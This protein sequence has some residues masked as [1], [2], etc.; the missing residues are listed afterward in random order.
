MLNNMRILVV[1]D[2]RGI[3]E[4]ASISLEVLGFESVATAR[5]GQDALDQVQ[6][7]STPF[8]CFLVDIQMPYVD[9]FELCA[10]IRSMPEYR[11][12]PI[13]MLTAMS[14]RKYIDRALAAGATD[15]VTKPFDIMDL[16]ARL[17]AAAL[18]CEKAR[19]GTAL[20]ERVHALADDLMHTTM[21]DIGDTFDIDDVPGYLNYDTF[22]DL[23]KSFGESGAQ[24]A[25]FTAFQIADIHSIYCRCGSTAYFNFICDVSDAVSDVVAT[26][27]YIFSYL[28]NGVFLVFDPRSGGA[29][30]KAGLGEEIERQIWQL[31]L[32]FSD[33][34]RIPVKLEQ[35]NA[36]G[37]RE[38]PRGIQ[39]GLSSDN[40]QPLY[41]TG[42]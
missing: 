12:A 5:D 25:E 42:T 24:G 29:Q 38:M 19:E 13:I 15:Y 2:D 31:D 6:S 27:G 36:F 17:N 22:K 23:V 32:R 28:G 35:S 37:F 39:P 11:A 20:S 18:V 3:R 1:D 21:V 30:E 4:L 16:K 7:A 33:G 34:N 9:G 40:V 8:E 14:D 10:A 41:E 26:R